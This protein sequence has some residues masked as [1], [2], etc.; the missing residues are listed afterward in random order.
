MRDDLRAQQMQ[1]VVEL[2]VKGHSAK[3]EELGKL[4]EEL[5][6]E[7]RDRIGAE[8]P[9]PPV[10]DP[11]MLPIVRKIKAI[12]DD[13][14]TSEAVKLDVGRTW[15]LRLAMTDLISKVQD[16]VI[17]IRHEARTADEDTVRRLVRTLS[18]SGQPGKV[19]HDGLVEIDPWWSEERPDAR[20]ELSAG[21][22]GPS[23]HDEFV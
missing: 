3:V 5:L 16:L 15:H 14:G 17:S 12:Q 9:L 8:V 1:R 21:G 4:V 18:E 19:L 2:L 6:Q 11:P 10:G 7:I 13:P 22:D 23:G 20:P